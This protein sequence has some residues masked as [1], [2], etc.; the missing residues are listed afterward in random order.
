MRSGVYLSKRWSAG[1]NLRAGEDEKKF[2]PMQCA[3][4]R[5]G[6]KREGV[7]ARAHA[8]RCRKVRGSCPTKRDIAVADGGW[9]TA[10]GKHALTLTLDLT[11]VPILI[12]LPVV[13]AWTRW[14]SQGARE[15]VCSLCIRTQQ[16]FDECLDK[17]NSNFADAPSVC[18]G[19]KTQGPTS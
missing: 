17:L 11:S 2:R 5:G 6:V 13:Q 16:A 19:R 3:L 7:K 1:V 8:S 4:I 18:L 14:S 9:R 15:Y 12:S 10:E